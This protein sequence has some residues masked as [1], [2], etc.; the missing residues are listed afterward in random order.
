MISEQIHRN[1]DQTE[2]E[3]CAKCGEPFC[4]CA[5]WEPDCS[6]PTQPEH[7]PG[8][9]GPARG[10]GDDEV[11]CTECHQPYPRSEMHPGTDLCEDCCWEINQE[12]EA[13]MGFD[14]F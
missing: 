4:D 6:Q 9:N 5:T 3:L 2:S 13:S 12:C 10:E 7:L 8:E 11:L 14:S 1:E